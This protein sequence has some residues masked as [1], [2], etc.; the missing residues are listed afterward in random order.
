[1]HYA[2][3]QGV[4]PDSIHIDEAAVLDEIDS[5]PLKEYVP[6]YYWEARPTR[7]ERNPFLRYASAAR[8]VWGD[9]GIIARTTA[10]A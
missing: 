7:A 9:P 2:R 6:E 4:T 5:N 10:A 3:L 1:M 8:H